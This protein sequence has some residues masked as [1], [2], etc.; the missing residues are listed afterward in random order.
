MP[1]VAG[2]KEGQTITD[3]FNYTVSDGSLTD[4]A[5][6]TM[7]INGAH[8]GPVA[9]CATSTTAGATAATEAGG[10]NNTPAG[11]IV[12]VIVRPT[13]TSTLFP[14]TTLFRSAIRTGG[15]EGSGSA[16]TV[17]SALVGAHGT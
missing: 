14:Y 9:V 16:G 8:D 7:T 1:A 3:S 12:T 13:P 11:S 17:G 15:V 10:T 6:L 2:I 5:V 4:T